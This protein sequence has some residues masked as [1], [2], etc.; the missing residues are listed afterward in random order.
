MSKKKA[1]YFS[2]A[3][4]DCA[5]EFVLVNIQIC[6]EHRRLLLKITQ[7][8]HVNYVILETNILVIVNKQKDD[9]RGLL[10]SKVQDGPKFYSRYG[11]EKFHDISNTK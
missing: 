11:Q 6:F 7:Q 2:L 4:F 1:L 9:R 5:V 10:V 3:H 8:K